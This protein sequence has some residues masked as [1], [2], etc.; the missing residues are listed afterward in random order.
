MYVKVGKAVLKKHI[1][2]V[3]LDCF[4]VVG[5]CTRKI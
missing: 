5:F 4:L 3:A 2:P 1:A